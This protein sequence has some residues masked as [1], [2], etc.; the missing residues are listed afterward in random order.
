[1]QSKWFQI[2]WIQVGS[3]DLNAMTSIVRGQPNEET[4][5]AV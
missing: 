1:M 3:N 4:K 2:D 5:I